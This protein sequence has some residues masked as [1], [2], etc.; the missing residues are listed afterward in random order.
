MPQERP[1]AI[2]TGSP[3]GAYVLREL[4]GRPQGSRSRPSSELIERKCVAMR[5]RQR[6][7]VS[8]LCSMP[9]SELERV[10]I[11]YRLLELMRGGETPFHH[12]WCDAWRLAVSDGPVSEPCNTFPRKLSWYEAIRIVGSGSV[13]Q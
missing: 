2:V 3:D 8:Q 5:K 1:R 11:L 4:R 12:L 6:A 10:R 13:C 7:T 9:D